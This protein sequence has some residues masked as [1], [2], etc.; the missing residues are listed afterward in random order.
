[1]VVSLDS[2]R[3]LREKPDVSKKVSSE[4]QKKPYRNNTGTSSP[5]L[6]NDSQKTKNS[7]KKKSSEKHTNQYRTQTS[8]T[9]G[10]KGIC[11][12]GKKGKRHRWRKYP[13]W[14]LGNKSFHILLEGHNSRVP[15]ACTFLHDPQV[16]SGRDLSGQLLPLR[17]RNRHGN[18]TG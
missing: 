6:A 17:G 18:R 12:C 10:T 3:D 9:A 15:A 11:P 7:R 8:I 5:H 16:L 2:S 4:S 1:M 13:R 14:S